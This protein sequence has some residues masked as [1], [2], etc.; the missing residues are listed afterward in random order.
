MH[1][2]SKPSLLWVSL[3][4]PEHLKSKKKDFEHA[5]R[6]CKLHSVL[7]LQTCQP[8]SLGRRALFLSIKH[9]EISNQNL[10][11]LKNPRNNIQIIPKRSPKGKNPEKTY[12]QVS[13]NRLLWSSFESHGSLKP[14]PKTFKQASVEHLPP[15]S[16]VPESSKKYASPILLG[17]SEVFLRGFSIFLGSFSKGFL[18]CFRCFLI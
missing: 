18:G 4:F 15:L 1:T 7:H 5:Q 2:K 3:M 12:P 10:D 6:T 11:L 13:K 9:L 17:F 8:L 16:P 14:L